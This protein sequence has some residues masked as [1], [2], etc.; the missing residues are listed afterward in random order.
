MRRYAAAALLLGACAPRG[1]AVQA[2]DT[3]VAGGTPSAADPAL[4]LDPS[5]GDALL[6]WEGGDSTSWSVYFARSTDQGA[7]WS[8]AVRI[9][10]GGTEV[11]P[12]GESSPRL[13]A[14]PDG[15]IALIWA[16]SVP[17]SGRKWPAA[18]MRMARSVDGGKTWS[19][20]L[21]LNDDTTG[22]PV[23]HQ[24]HGAA[25][26]GDSGLVVA[27]LDEREVAEASETPE[28]QSH[29]SHTSGDVTS[30]PDAAVYVATSNDF[31]LTWTAN[32]RAWGAA[33][34]CCRIVLA[35]G[36]DGQV[37]G[38]WRQ[39]FPGNVRD[40]VL[41]SMSD[42]EHPPTPVHADGWVYPGCPHAGPSVSVARGTAHV[43]WY[44]GKPGAAGMFYSRRPISGDTAT[45]AP[46]P[47]VT[48]KNVPTAHGTV[49]AMSDGGALAAWDL[50][51][52]ASGV[53]VAR[54]DTVGKLA[55]TTPVSGSAG[56]HYPQLIALR[57]GTVLLAWTMPV[58]SG[59][60]IRLAKVTKGD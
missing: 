58:G 31:G 14:G 7:S 18:A 51:D 17:V 16:N 48:G 25:W 5:T 4:A 8:P 10:G 12:H 38:A 29:L 50:I 22:T 11:H 59:S 46:V 13:V 60:A 52:G 42:A 15:K 54:L 9:A 37:F 39:H 56:A 55:G 6:A 32:H 53:T 27:W 33:C 57:D 44:T 1:P 3:S 19:T 40:V 24:F 28:H 30:E 21:T 2:L 49:V 35:R 20:P 41:A 36:D 34:P 45:V 47:L 26:A 23:S 43:L